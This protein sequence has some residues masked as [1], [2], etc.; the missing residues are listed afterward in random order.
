MKKIFLFIG[1]VFPRNFLH[2]LF[3][4]LPILDLIYRGKKYTDPINQKSYRD[5]LNYGHVKTRKS[6]LSPGTL[7]LERHRLLWL[8]LNRETDFFKKKSKV[9]HIAPEIAFIKKIS[10]IKN[11]DYYSCDFNSPLAKIKADICNLPFENKYFDWVLC[12]HVLE[13]IKDDKSAIKEIFRVLKPG[14]KAI[15]QVPLNKNLKKTVEDDTITKKEDRIRVFGQH[16][17]LRVYGLDYFKKLQ[18][19]GF[20]VDKI[21]YGSKLSRD[22][23]TRYRVAKDEYIPLCTKTK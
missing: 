12:N 8:F 15:M 19:V 20:Y 6:V 21:K 23:I 7:S 9:L 16:D 18:A 3:F 5:F 1:R 17:H 13:H 2:K 10:S 11:I 14:G 22:E 4:L